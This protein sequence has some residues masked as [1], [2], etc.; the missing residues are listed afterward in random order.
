MWIKRLSGGTETETHPHGILQKIDDF[1]HILVAQGGALA[2][3]LGEHHLVAELDELAQAL[4]NL[5]RGAA[6]DGTMFVQG[7]RLDHC[8]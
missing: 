3:L 4:V 8:D 7:V 1:P 5:L 2:A 6:H